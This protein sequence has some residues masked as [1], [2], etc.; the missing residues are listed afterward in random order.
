MGTQFAM[1]EARASAGVPNFDVSRGESRWAVLPLSP[2]QALRIRFQA[3]AGAIAT[4]A[5]SYAI[6]RILAALY[7]P[8]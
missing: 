6:L 2:G 5:A 3:L 1:V 8:R 4:G 7:A